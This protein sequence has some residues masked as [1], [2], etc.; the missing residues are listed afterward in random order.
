VV[1]SG[2]RLMQA[3]NRAVASHPQ[4][5]ILARPRCSICRIFQSHLCIGAPL[6]RWASE[7][8]I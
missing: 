1:Q 8:H 7:G 5:Q 6:Q 3:E 2:Q 4:G